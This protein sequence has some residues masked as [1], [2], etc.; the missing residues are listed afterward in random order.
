MVD[1]FNFHHAAKIGWIWRLCENKH[2]KWKLIILKR[3]GIMENHL[4]KK[5]DQS[6]INKITKFDKQVLTSWSLL[7]NHIP[8]NLEEILKEYI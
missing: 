4:N 5:L 3:M 8:E 1:I 6:L 7:Y 2:E